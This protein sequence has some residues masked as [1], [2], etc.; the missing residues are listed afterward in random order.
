MGNG[1]ITKPLGTVL[2]ELAI[3]QPAGVGLLL[4]IESA[5]SKEDV[6][7]DPDV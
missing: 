2:D 1:T 6:D 4:K 5:S 3:N 7:A